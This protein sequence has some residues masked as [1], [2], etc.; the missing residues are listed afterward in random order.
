MRFV[1]A[2]I[3][4]FALIL[5]ANGV[6]AATIFSSKT[7]GCAIELSGEIVQGDAERLAAIADQAGLTG[8]IDSGEA[9]NSAE[10]ALCLNSPGG[11]YVEG[12]N[13]AHFVHKNGIATRTLATSECYSSCAFVFMAGHSLGGEVDGPRRILTIGGKL[14]FHAPYFA[15]DP[16]KP[17]TGADT[18]AVSVLSMQLISDFIKFSSYASPFDH[19]P[20]FSMSLLGDTLGMMP[21]QL[22]LVDTVEEAARWAIELDGTRE[23]ALLNDRQLVQA[24][25]NFQAW[26]FDLPSTEVTEFKWYL[27]LKRMMLTLWGEEREFGLV[28]TGGMEVRHCLVEANNT[29]E[30]GFI[31]CSRDE[32]N[33]VMLGDCEHGF[34]SWEPWYYAL[35]PATPLTQLR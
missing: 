32:F 28:D 25:V 20:M 3:A 1:R 10:K 19:R 4:S 13:M 26:E 24:C 35:P 14:G 15:L 16:D 12:R 29:K 7:P 11:S 6:L 30:S 31:I 5:S 22:E 33:G 9:K 17:V 34:G 2:F 8:A 18:N 23:K 21:D 27:P